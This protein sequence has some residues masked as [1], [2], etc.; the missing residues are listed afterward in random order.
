MY[1]KYNE[2]NETDFGPPAHGKQT[3][4]T[5]VLSCKETTLTIANIHKS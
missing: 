3:T 2:N 5:G 1:T 4:K